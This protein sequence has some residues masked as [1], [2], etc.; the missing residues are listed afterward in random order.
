[1]DEFQK[2]LGD[3]INEVKKSLLDETQQQMK[4]KAEETEEIKLKST[5]KKTNKVAL[6]AI[7][8][9][10][11]LE[12]LIKQEE[13]EREKREEQMMLK[14]IE[15]EKRKSDCLMRAIKEKQLENQ[16]NLKQMETAEAIQNIKKAAIQEV[17]TRRNNLK[18]LIIDM[19]S[20][21]KRKTN[22][23]SQKLQAVR[24]E[25]AKQMGIA[26]K[27]GDSTNCEKIKKGVEDEQ[28]KEMRKHY[29]VANF[30]E[31]FVNY[32]NCLDGED[33]CHMC[34]D[35]EFGDFYIGEREKCYKKACWCYS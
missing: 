19:R 25:M 28:R 9:E 15:E 14:K 17:Q 22:S 3:R 7:Q 8:K 21:Q 32:Q 13:I 5:I 1:M 10:L 34:C 30:S 29:C 18:K 24:Y 31:D 16:Y 26:Y 23:L 35:N 2:R 27:K 20:K 6:Q 11:N 4:R 12:E 33:F